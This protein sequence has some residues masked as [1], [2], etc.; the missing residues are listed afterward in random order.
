MLTREEYLDIKKSLLKEL[1]APCIS[2]ERRDVIEE[3]LESIESFLEETD[4]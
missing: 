3:T 2:V 1:S 4:N